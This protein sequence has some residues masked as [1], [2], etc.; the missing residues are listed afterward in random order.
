MTIS[1]TYE[2]ARLTSQ[3]WVN[4][5]QSRCRIGTDRS[6]YV[7]IARVRGNIHDFLLC[8]L[9]SEK[10]ERNRSE[11]GFPHITMSAQDLNNEISMRIKSLGRLQGVPAEPSRSERSKL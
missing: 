4:G 2:D 10:F 9:G 11:T 5:P 6:D 3:C 7:L 1:C 8:K